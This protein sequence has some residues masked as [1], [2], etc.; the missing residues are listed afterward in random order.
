MLSSKA[1]CSPVTHL[2]LTMQVPDG[3][4]LYRLHR[5][6]LGLS[7]ECF[8]TLLSLQ[9]ED[10]EEGTS[11]THPVVLPGIRARDFDYFLDYHLRQYVC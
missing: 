1:A 10:Q 7:S 5:S 8:Q 2:C 11:D 4:I 3:N 9:P 6:I